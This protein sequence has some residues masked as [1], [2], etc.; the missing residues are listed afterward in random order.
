[1]ADEEA[2]NASVSGDGSVNGS[3]V[4]GRVTGPAGSPVAGVDLALYP[5]EDGAGAEPLE[6]ESDSEGAFNFAELTD[7]D[8]RARYVSDPDESVLIARYNDWFWSASGDFEPES[9]A[10]LD[11]ALRDE[12]IFGP[13]LATSGS[14]RWHELSV[15]T[16]WRKVD[17]P[18]EQTLFLEVT[19]VRSAVDREPFE[20][21]TDSNDLRAGTFSVTVPRNDVRINFGPQTDVG[22]ED[23]PP[24]QV[25]A[26]A[27]GQ[28]NPEL[29]DWHPVR[30]GLPLFGIGSGYLN[31]SSTGSEAED[32][33]E[34]IVEGVGRIVNGLPGIGTVLSLADAAEFVIGD[35][36]K[37]TA[38]LGDADVGFPDPTN[39]ENLARVPDPNT[40]TSALLGWRFPDE[41]FSNTAGGSVVMMVPMELEADG[42]SQATAHAEWLHPFARV[43][44]G[45][46]FEL[47]RTTLERNTPDVATDTDG[48]DQES[49]ETAGDEPAVD[50]YANEDGVV[51]TGGLLDAAGDFGSGEIDA[52]T[53]VDVVTSFRPSLPFG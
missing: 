53:M 22:G 5:F 18:G 29:A 19:N 27:T 25:L 10:T 21:V 6:T 51:D 13:E 48:N 16:C 14:G 11:I 45:E 33:P 15:M 41:T 30:T 49:T 23:T 34:T 32:G 1:M 4:S 3:I 8:T 36:L 35:P 17:R 50:D 12:L 52:D 40:H 47:S 46:V 2:T 43:T 7:P 44:F 38:S 9:A 39:P 26:L 20:V 28:E 31:L 42:V 24:A 37:R